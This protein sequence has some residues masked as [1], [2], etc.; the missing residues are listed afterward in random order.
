MFHCTKTIVLLGHGILNDMELSL[1]Q[2]RQH[3]FIREI[4]RLREN[5]L[6]LKKFRLINPASCCTQA[7]E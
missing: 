3:L 1:Y 6:K 5:Q 7:K 2:M 4:E